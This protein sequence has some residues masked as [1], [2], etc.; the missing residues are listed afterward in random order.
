MVNN[1]KIKVLY[2]ADTAPPKKDGV[3]RFMLETA[4][5]LNSEKFEVSFL[6]PKVEGSEQAIKNMKLDAT[7]VPVR[8]FKI[9]TYPPAVPKSDIVK[10]AIDK[11]DIVFINSIAP[12]GSSALK[13]GKKIGKPVIEF[14][15]SIDWEL[16][17]YATKFPD[18]YAGALKPIVRRLYHKS[19]LLLVANKGLRVI[20]KSAKIKNK[21]KILPLGVDIKKFKRDRIKR[22]YIRRELGLK[23]NVVIGYHGRLSKEKN[24]KMLATAFNQIRLKIPNA[25][26]LIMGDGPQ[27]K[28]LRG[29][30]DILTTGFVDNP[31]DYLQAIDIYVLPSM[32][33][34]TGLALMEAMSCGLACI[35]TNVGAIPSYVQDGKNGIL[36]DKNKLDANIL[37]L[38]IEK[39][40]RNIKLR[41]EIKQNAPKTIDCC[42]TWDNTTKELERIFES[43]IK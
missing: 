1:N 7:F 30:P 17:A 22:V 23:D 25:K 42:Y 31:E 8:H 11:T 32:T 12:L 10:K 34:T 36:L 6:L 3:V 26:L 2:V 35:A 5:R 41:N 27:M 19:D 38:V 4:K 40:H 15:H 29:N 33:E 28:F 14:V 24:I 39:L 13:Y 9:A 18:K 43:M 20:L 21:I 37:S 16:F